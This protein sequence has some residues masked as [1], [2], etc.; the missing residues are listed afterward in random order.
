MKTGIRHALTLLLAALLLP[1]A[2]LATDK[3]AINY[4]PTVTFT[5]RTDVAEGKLVYIGIGGN[6]DGAVNP[7]ATFW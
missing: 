4:A 2:A 5:L 6:I 3:G 1:A 7:A